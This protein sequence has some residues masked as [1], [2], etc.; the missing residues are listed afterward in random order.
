MRKDGIN[1]GKLVLGCT[2]RKTPYRRH[3]RITRGPHVPKPVRLA[4]AAQL[5]YDVVDVAV[6]LIFFQS[7][8][9]L[10]RDL[11]GILSSKREKEA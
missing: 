9:R 6:N 11:H 2:Q 5:L 1:K 7:F 3:G 8:G 4:Q 10:D